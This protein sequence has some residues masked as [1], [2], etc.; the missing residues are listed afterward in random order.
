MGIVVCSYDTHENKKRNMTGTF[1]CVALLS[2]QP[3]RCLSILFFFFVICPCGCDGVSNFQDLELAHILRAAGLP[4]A[5][6]RLLLFL[7]IGDQDQ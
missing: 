4:I 5:W 7:S 2:V 3:W 6:V 1:L